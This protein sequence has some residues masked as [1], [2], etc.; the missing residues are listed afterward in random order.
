MQFC[1]MRCSSVSAVDYV[2]YVYINR[3][4]GATYPVKKQQQKDHTLAAS[5]VT[6]V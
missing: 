3:Y 4:F 6:L 5:C 2:D 1:L